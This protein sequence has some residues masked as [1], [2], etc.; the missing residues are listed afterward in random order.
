MRPLTFF[1]AFSNGDKMLPSIDREAPGGPAAL[2]LETLV[3]LALRRSGGAIGSAGA[4]IVSRIRNLF[5]LRAIK[6][7]KKLLTN[8]AIGAII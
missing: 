1:C 4:I 6:F 5:H 7:R 3:A 8:A 2:N